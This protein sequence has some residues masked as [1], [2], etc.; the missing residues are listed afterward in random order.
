MN[1][2][3]VTLLILAVAPQLWSRNAEQTSHDF[4]TRKSLVNQP[5]L[6]NVFNK[7]LS[8]E[9][10]AALEFL[11]AYMP[12]PDMTDYSG[13][14]YL[15]NVKLALKARDEMPWGATVPEREWYHFVLPVRVN[16]ENLDDSRRVFFTDLKERVKGKST[17]DAVL[18]VNHWCHEKVTYQPSDSRTS[19]PLASIKSA[20]GRCGEESTFTV[21]ALRAIG[22]PAR[23]VYT[24]RWAHTDDNHA[25][26]EAWIDGKWH[27]LGACEPEAILDLG[28]FNAPASRGMLMNTKAFGRY[29]GPEQ[30]LSRSNCYTEINV[31]S[32][33]APVDTLKVKIVDSTNHPVE[34]A[35]VDFRLYN[36]A[37]YYPIAT[38]KTDPNGCAA[39]VAGLGDL[40]IWASHNGR[41]AVRKCTIGK[42][43]DITITLNETSAPKGVITLDAVP[44]VQSSALP[45]VPEEMAQLNNQRKQQE[46]SIRNAYTATFYT[47][48]RAK[49][50]AETHN[51]NVD[52]L[53]PLLVGARGNHAT[54]TGFLESVKPE[55][56]PK[57]IALLKAISDKDLRDI[58]SNILIDHF[59]TSPVDNPLYA[60]YIMN[61]RVA[62]EMLTPYKNYFYSVIPDDMRKRMTEN[63]RKWV[64]WCAD[65]ITIDQNWNPQSLRMSPKAVWECRMTDEGSRDIF[66]VAA[67]RSMGIPARIDPVTEKTQYAS[68]NSEWIDADFSTPLASGST[69]GSLNLSFT[70]SG[71]ISD[72]AYYTHFTLS[73]IVDGVPQ[74]LNYPEEATW[75]EIFSSPVKLDTGEYLLTTG[76][77]MASGAV[78]S[79]LTFFNIL[80]DSITETALTLR[81]DS[82]E[83][84][85]IGN[86]NSE[87]IYHDT[88]LGTD[89]SLLSTT[90]RGYYVLGLIT[91]NDEPSVHALNDIS[92][93][94]DEFEKD[95]RSIMLLFA[96]QAG[97]SKWDASRFPDLPSNVTFGTDIDGKIAEELIN[98]LELDRNLRPIFI[99]ADTFNRVVYVT[100]G[101]TIGTGQRLIETLHR[102]K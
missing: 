89:K 54:I 98:G 38:I 74:L 25:W 76:Q 80:P 44:P 96:D 23:Q 37:E 34:N 70:P 19:S 27:F 1:R 30:Q 79:Q 51:Y 43:K 83:I 50:Y 12:F 4:E 8:A 84:S 69:Q 62:N 66:F 13:E 24:P 5:S 29:D 71:H 75:S 42:D 97:A 58:T 45:E 35:R 33:Y 48:D 32:N 17:A 94:K 92:A 3:I 46:D 72:P 85:V 52:E 65:N 59:N 73:K 95:G 40:L 81:Q 11:Y 7:N 9:E 101:Y 64:E 78:L 93:Y 31:T 2:L 77:R 91:A 55:D 15:E 53:V 28:W 90:G 49:A 36:Y 87:N 21:A 39:L 67:A 88:A 60:D 99:I 14:Y 68:P 20:Y 86:F 100:Q 41:Y 26:V 63:P 22:I 18:E 82:T 47:A 6:Y 16:N 57:A 10:R 61:P 56:Q 102:L